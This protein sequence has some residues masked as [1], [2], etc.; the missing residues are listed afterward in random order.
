MQFIAYISVYSIYCLHFNV[1]YLLLAFQYMVFIACISMYGIYCLHFCI[2]Y[3][4][5]PEILNT[6]SYFFG[7]A[8]YAV[9]S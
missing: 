2:W 9:V 3:S 6:I 4:E 1:W 7:L 5:C 8:F